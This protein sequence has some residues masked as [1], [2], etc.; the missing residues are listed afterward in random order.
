MRVTRDGLYVWSRAL[1]HKAKGVT[2]KIPPV[3]KEFVSE[4]ITIYTLAEQ[5]ALANRRGGKAQ[6][7]RP[8]GLS[9]LDTPQFTAPRV[10]P[11]GRIRPPRL[12]TSPPAHVSPGPS[13]PAGIKSNAH[14]S[15]RGV[16]SDPFETP[17]DPHRLGESGPPARGN[18]VDLD[19]ASD[20]DPRSIPA[21]PMGTINRP[22]GSRSS[23][24]IEVW[25]ADRS[26]ARKIARSPGGGGI[27]VGRLD[28]NTSGPARGGPE[29]SPTR[30][31][32]GSNGTASV[33]S[34]GTSQVL[35]MGSGPSAMLSMGSAVLIPPRRSLPPLN[36][37]GRALGMETFLDLCNFQR[38][39]L[40]P[41][42]LINMAHIRHWEFFYRNTDV[43]QLQRMGFPYP[44]ASQLMNGAEYVGAT[45][46]E[47]PVDE[48]E[49]EAANHTRQDGPGEDDDQEDPTANLA[50][51][52]TQAPALSPEY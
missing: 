30:K 7:A 8:T 12:I 50:G 5:S 3:T 2:T 40:V 36:D 10:M 52:D 24:D 34:A 11:C 42:V 48:P 46:T 38:D 13:T 23:T 1:V 18:V 17:A 9:S 15:S 29:T 39:D 35:S 31:I 27:S 32:A 43:I 37:L 26:P 20:D 19:A 45:H 22:P 6:S 28:Y 41:R 47:A 16:P 4:P 14:E 44:I 33:G 25:S 51:A 49:D 21:T